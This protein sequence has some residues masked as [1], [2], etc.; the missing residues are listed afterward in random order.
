MDNGV[1]VWDGG[2]TAQKISTQ[3]RDDFFMSRGIPIALGSGG[4]SLGYN[5]GTFFNALS[6]GDLIY[7]SNGWIYNSTLGSWWQQT[8]ANGQ[9]VGNY[10]P[11]MWYASVPN[12]I[13]HPDPGGRDHVIAACPATYNSTNLDVGVFLAKDWPYQFWSWQ[14][15][16]FLLDDGYWFDI[17]EFWIQVSGP[18][19]TE[20]TINLWDE[21]TVN[22]P[23]GGFQKTI[24]V[25]SLGPE[26]IRFKT[27][28][29]AESFC[30]GI[31]ALNLGSQ[32]PCICYGFDILYKTMNP[33]AVT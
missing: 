5:Q 21:T 25:N 14:S 17:S 10:E 33:V 29:K 4:S 18:L 16:P 26:W 9:A 22:G 30:V 32:T 3:L 11:L 28:F 13:A 7:V 8:G 6:D 23:A 1:W 27:N 12:N 20:F 19:G 31:S 2:A 24:Y 15:N